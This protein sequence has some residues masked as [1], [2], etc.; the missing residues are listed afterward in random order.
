MDKYGAIQ[1]QER[2]G[3]HGFNMTNDIA[4]NSSKGVSMIDASK[5]LTLRRNQ[6]G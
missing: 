5:T 1:V 4:A 3:A 2:G 6:D